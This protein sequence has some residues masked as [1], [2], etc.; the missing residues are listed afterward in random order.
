MLNI[1][2]CNQDNMNQVEK[3][4]FSKI[5]DRELPAHFLYEDDICVAILDIFPAVTGQSI[6]IPKKA[7]DYVFSLDTDTYNHI[8][9]VAQKVAIASDQALQTERTCLV[10]E[11]FEVPH[12]HIKLYPVPDTSTPLGEIMPN[13]QAVSDTELADTAKLIKDC[14]NT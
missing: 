6:I 2:I 11:G 1:R 4:I 3:S 12:V 8:F 5:I 10:V 13:G 9:M 7:I 14:L